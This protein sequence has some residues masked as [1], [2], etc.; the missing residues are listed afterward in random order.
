MRGAGVN[1]I[2]YIV[3]NSQR[4]IKVCITL[5]KSMLK[6]VNKNCDSVTTLQPNLHE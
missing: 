5:L 1:A 6:H 4:I 3:W 2:K